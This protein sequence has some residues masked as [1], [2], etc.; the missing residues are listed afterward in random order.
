VGLAERL[1]ELRATSPDPLPIA[2][3]RDLTLAD[4]GPG[5]R[6]NSATRKINDDP[7]QPSALGGICVEVVQDRLTDDE[8]G[9]VIPRTRY[10]CLATWRPDPFR[11]PV[12]EAGEVALDAELRLDRMAA[13]ACVGW[14]IRPVVTSNR[15]V[16]SAADLAAW[17]DAH[18]LVV[19]IA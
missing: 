5:W 3:T 19:A 1:A 18:R 11:W 8:T 7:Y 6:M 9:E 15:R 17:T 14:L 4:V 2:G 12:L 10:R 13:W 16:P